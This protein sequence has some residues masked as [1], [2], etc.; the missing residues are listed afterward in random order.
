VSDNNS[1]PLSGVR[2]ADLSWFGAGPI[3]GQVLATF[4]AEVIRVESESHLDGLRQA[5][6]VRPGYV[7]VNGSGY[8][9]NFNAGKYSLTI[10]LNHPRAR[11]LALR[12]LCRCD[13]MLENFP[14]RVV[15]KWGLTYDEIRAVNAVG[16]GPYSTPTPFVAAS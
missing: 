13:V 3:A 1:L 9:N 15:E 5:Q 12:L 7:G 16:P 4:G 6:P 14:P 8:Y 10:N 2:V 11:A